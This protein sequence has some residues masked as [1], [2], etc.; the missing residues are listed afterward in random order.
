MV[1]GLLWSSALFAE[2]EQSIR[3]KYKSSLP[4]CDNGIVIDMTDTEKWMHWNN[5]FGRLRVKAPDNSSMVIAADYRV[6]RTG[7]EIMTVETLNEP[8]PEIF[9]GHMFFKKLTINGC[10]KNGHAISPIG[11]LYKIKWNKRCDNV[12][13]MTQIN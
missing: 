9:P 4:D 8:H 5:C 7:V 10:K 6:D 11:K 3:D 1:L 13:K 2:T 12:I